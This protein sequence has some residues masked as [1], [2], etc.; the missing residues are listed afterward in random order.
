MLSYFRKF[1]QQTI[2]NTYT[3]NNTKKIKIKT[4]FLKNSSH[5]R[6]PLKINQWLNTIITLKKFHNNSYVQSA[7]KL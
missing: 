6:I 5:H 1:K 4:L 7:K 3:W 2:H